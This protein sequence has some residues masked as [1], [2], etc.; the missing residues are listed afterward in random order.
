MFRHYLLEF[1]FERKLAQY[2]ISGMHIQVFFV[3]YKKL[4]LVIWTLSLYDANYKAIWKLPED[5]LSQISS[6][7]LTLC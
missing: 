2:I 7:Y 6:E 1:S 5:C 3:F 4:G